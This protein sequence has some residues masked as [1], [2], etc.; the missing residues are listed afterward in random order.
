[1]LDFG[2]AKAVDEGPISA[3]ASNSPTLSLAATQAGVI[4][5]TA[6]YMS[7]DQARGR[8]VDKRSDIW[9][10]GVALYEMLSGEQ[11]FQGHTV[12]DVLASVLRHEIDWKR[13]SPKAARLLRR[14]L[15]RD[16]S[17]RL[18][19]IGDIHLLPEDEP[20]EAA[21]S[22]SR[23]SWRLGLAGWA[24]AAFHM[25]LGWVRPFPGAGRKMADLHR[26]D[27]SDVVTHGFSIVFR[28]DLN[29]SMVQDNGVQKL[30]NYYFPPVQ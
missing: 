11:L 17:L 24:I 22:A 9:A 27:I 14:C 29:P 2:R 30:L 6:A 23:S 5:G 20:P 13:V 4:L 1:M 28:K 12:S 8:A 26:R 21:V 15:E 16:P 18:R 3:T 25:V 19:D 7:P 10:F